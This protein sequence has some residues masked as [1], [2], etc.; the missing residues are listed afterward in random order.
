MLY[1]KKDEKVLDNELFANP[2]SEYRGAPFWAWN[3]TL[4]KDELL[5]QIERFKEMG[6]GGFHMHVRSGMATEYLSDEF[7]EL[8]AA[9]VEK[10]KKEELLAWLYDEDRYPS[11]AAGGMV[12]KEF[13]HRQKYLLITQNRIYDAVDKTTGTETGKPYLIAT[14]DIEFNN[15][16]EILS[17]KVIGE[18]DIVKGTKVYAYVKAQEPVGWKKGW[19]NEQTYV[20]TMSKDAMRKFIDVTYEA[21]KRKVGKDFGSAVPSIFTDEPQYFVS[22]NKACASDGKDVMFAY[23]TDFNDSFYSRKGYSFVE[24]IPELVWNFSGSK[25]SYVRYDYYDH[26]CE[27]FVSAFCDQVG[28][29]CAENGILFTGHVLY[30]ES[31]KRQTLAVGEAMRCYRNFTL[32]GIDMLVNRVEL[33]TA[34]QTQSVVHQYSREGMMSELYGVTGWE[35]D[36]RGHKFQGDWQAALGVTVRVHHLS[37]MSMKGSAKRDYPASIHYQ[38]PWYKR[39]NLVEDHFARINTV[40]TRGKPDVKV[41]IIHPIESCWLNHGPNDCC[42]DTINSLDDSFQKVMRDMFATTIDFDFISESLGAEIYGGVQDKKLKIGDMSYSAVVIP[43]VSTLRKTTINFLT[44]FILAG[45]K[46]ITLSNA[47]DYVDG[48]QSDEAK[49][50]YELATPVEFSSAGLSRALSDERDVE[51]RLD[52]GATVTDFVYNMRI[53]GNGKWLFLART[54]LPKNTPN[55]TGCSRNITIKIKGHYRPKVYNTIN[56]KIYEIPFISRGGYTTLSYEFFE[57]DSL[58]LRLDDWVE[59]AYN[60]KYPMQKV[61]KEIDFKQKVN[62][63]LTEP[64]VAVLDMAK[65]SWD[66][67]R[68]SDLDSVAR[69]DM[70]IRSVLRYPAADGVD[71]QPWVIKGEKPDKF[72]YLKFE[73]NSET[74]ANCRLAFEEA[75]EVE[76]NGVNVD[77]VKNGWFT[78]KEI[79]T[80]DLPNIKRGKNVLIVRAPIS[81]RISLENMFLLGDFGVRVEGSQFT[82]VKRSNK[83]AFGSIIPQGLP[84]YGAGVSY[85]MPI[86]TPNCDLKVHVP[87]Y[88]G[89][90]VG[91]SLDG[92]DCG[93]I[94]YAPYDLTIPNVK[95]GKHVITLTLYV[96]RVNCFGA[97]HDCSDSAWKGPATFYT[98][99]DAYSYEYYLKDNGILK[100]PIITLYKNKTIK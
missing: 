92:V 24:R 60:Y 88:Y 39:Y 8:V 30:E 84:F 91:V 45:G 23:T 73:F 70:Q 96:S 15:D 44:E 14:F 16:Y 80:M 55:A 63:S 62:Y 51:M 86:S 25:P 99:G 3:S 78:D 4:K 71:V 53:D 58:L 50:L 97:I 67:S 56:G 46:V 81:K 98:T 33:C 57:H 61:I 9:C 90:V 49:R 77:V 43:H 18:N 12:T 83:I 10:G 68:W 42:Y 31:L 52:D 64:N 94:A 22:H 41:A 1:K 11:G 65:Y 2:T 47:P 40:L 7:L 66:K 100:S 26:A 54:S 85:E 17:Y 29:W 72:P 20:D 38:S 28:K 59:E 93:N 69:I 32:P 74:Q 75:V 34:K 37:W 27:T 82:I 89:A 19:Y 79:Y 76:F 95:S 87:Y 6:M 36:F 48:R 5:W 21:Y 13:K 35:F